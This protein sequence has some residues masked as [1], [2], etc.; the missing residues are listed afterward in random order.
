MVQDSG[1]ELV[2]AGVVIEKG[3]QI[4]GKLLRDRGIHLESLP[5]SMVWMIKPGKLPSGN[6]KE[7]SK[8]QILLQELPILVLAAAGMVLAD[9]KEQIQC[10]TAAVSGGN[11]CDLFFQPER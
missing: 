3:F 8:W 5:S 9:K 6:S 11:Q 1:A 4:G 2:G 10:V 7:A